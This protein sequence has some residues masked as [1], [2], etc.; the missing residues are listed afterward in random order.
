[1]TAAMLPNIA[2]SKVEKTRLIFKLNYTLKYTFPRKIVKS[3]IED[4]TYSLD[5][6]TIEVSRSFIDYMKD[7]NVLDLVVELEK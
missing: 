4:A 5:A 6:K 3:S 7:P 2:M 1:M